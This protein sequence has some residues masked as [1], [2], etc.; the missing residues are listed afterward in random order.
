ME[1]KL[2]QGD[3]VPDGLGGI[4]RC[5][6]KDALL[7]LNLDPQERARLNALIMAS[8]VALSSPFGYLAGL[9]S[10]VDRR[11]PFA[12][13]LVLF[14]AAMLVVCPVQEPRVEERGDS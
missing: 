9:L 3:Y 13:S 5:K 7:Q 10:S 8:T 1:I 12:F 14:L 4:Q 2:V 11:L 6:G